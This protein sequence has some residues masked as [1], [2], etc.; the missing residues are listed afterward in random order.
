MTNPVTPTLANP[1]M[2]DAAF[3]EIQTKLLSKLSWLDHA[4]G[5]AQAMKQ[6]KGEGEES[7]P[8]VFVGEK[9]YLKMFPDGTIGNFTF[10]DAP[11]VEDV[12]EN[13]RVNKT[14]Q[15]VFQLI[16]WGDL[17]KVY[18]SDWT[19]RTNENVKQELIEFFRLNSFPSARVKILRMFDRASDIYQG[20][21]NRE[22]EDQFLMRPY[23][24]FRIEGEIK[25]TEK[26]IC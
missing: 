21:A 14:L 20:Y 11:N 18:P 25:Y 6:I 5:K 19:L 17:R 4:Y 24:G 13:G 22:I 16:V 12:I 10:F 26:P 15:T 8:A 23:F 1:V 9:S 3:Q 7:F 2:L